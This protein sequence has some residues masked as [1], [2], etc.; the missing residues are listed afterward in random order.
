MLTTGFY[1]V[2]PGLL[3]AV[4]THL[5]MRA[6]PPARPAKALPR[7]SLVHVEHP[8][9][10]WYRRLF[11]AVG[12]DWLWFSRLAMRDADLAAIISDPAVEIRVL[13]DADGRD[14][15]LLELDFRKAGACELAFF[16]VVAE[17]QGRGAGWM[18]M[19]AALARAWG[20]PIDRMHVHTCTFDHPAALPFYIRSGFVPVARRVE[21]APDPR[22]T[23]LLPR[24]AAPHVPLLA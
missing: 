14:V 18:L 13:R 12:C 1:H 16:G 17:L 20:T 9:T 5:E 4:V 7:L 23:G 2:A 24:D 10:D 8:D 15:G 11:I 22:Q 21:V 6:A 19:Q 3:A